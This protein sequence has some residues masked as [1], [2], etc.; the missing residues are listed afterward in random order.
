MNAPYPLAE[1]GSL[2]APSPEGLSNVAL[3]P[4]GLTAFAARVEA[5][6]AAKTSLDL[7]YY[8]WRN[9]LT[10]QLLAREVL[11]AADRGVQ[12][13]VLLDDMYA[14]GRERVLGALGAH[15]QIELRLF[16]A[17]RWRRF[18]LLGLV[19]EMLFGGWHLNRRMHNK[20]WIADGRVAICGGRNIGDEYFDAADQINFRDLDLLIAGAAAQDAQAIFERYWNYKL[21]RPV[22]RIS[23]VAKRRGGFRALSLLL[24][25]ARK[26][27][28]ARPFFEG[29]RADPGVARVLAG[30]LSQLAAV[31]PRDIRVVADPPE[32]V[33][34]QAPE[35]ECLARAIHDALRG[36][37]KEALLISPYFVPGEEGAALL[38]ELSRQGVRVSVVTNSLAA[39]DVVAVHGGYALYRERLLEAG[40]ELH[41]LKPSGEEAVSVFGSR[42]ASLHTKALVIDGLHA[43]VGSFNLD[44][45]SATLNTEMGT[46]IRHEGVAAGLREEH[47]RLAEPARSWRVTRERPGHLLWTAEVQGREVTSRTEPEASLRRRFL[48]RLVQWLPIESQL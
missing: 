32:K 6:R 43:F 31:P 30:D 5:A 2:K 39:T 48:S 14:I 45:R 28:E 18:G 11:H 37:T 42:G 41:E 19:L 7:Q 17:T 34:G 24:D 8:N 47:A 22:W 29:L 23:P 9:D 20:A 16:N 21:S 10:G 27:P 13:R 44:P 3:M 33:R 40:V 4:G 35:K 25:A 36:A 26:T 46:F 12:V 15:P 38:E 1:A